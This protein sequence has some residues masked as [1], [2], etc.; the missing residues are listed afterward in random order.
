M[1]KKSSNINSK[2]KG[3]YSDL[4]SAFTDM[5]LQAKTNKEIRADRDSKL[6]SITLISL[7]EGLLFVSFTMEEQIIPNVTHVIEDYLKGIEGSCNR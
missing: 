5:F 1:K 2:I 6:L 7:I 4:Y 3:N